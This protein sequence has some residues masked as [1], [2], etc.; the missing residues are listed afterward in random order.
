MIMKRR[1][2]NFWI[3]LFGLTILI[4]LFG[5]SNRWSDSNVAES[6]KRGNNINK[7]L[8][9][10]KTENSIY[11]ERLDLLVPKYLEKIESPMAGN[12]KWIY[13]VYDSNQQYNLG[14]EGYSEKE[15][16]CWYGSKSKI[17]VCDTK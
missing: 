17:W 15:P 1:I 11:P 16:V 8:L 3:K 14:F 9:A 13:E 2:N 10:Y 4:S 5:C 12:R 7:A 6:K